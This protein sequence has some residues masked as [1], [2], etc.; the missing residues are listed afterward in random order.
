ML[1]SIAGAAW[2]RPPGQSGMV[3]TAA[4]GFPN[5]SPARN[6]WARMFRVLSA[7]LLVVLAR[8]VEPA[9][10]AALEIAEARY[11][12]IG[13]V[14]QWITIRAAKASNPV[15]L[16]LH[17]G[18]GDIQSPLP[19]IYEPLEQNFVF[20]QWDQRGAGRSLARAGM[21]QPASLEQ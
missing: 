7:T 2:S 14:E 3:R 18:P 4:A 1:A 13:G 6:V 12:R 8:P 5:F 11:Q 17:G 16:F 10:P 21:Q 19:E 20:V 15:L 9:R